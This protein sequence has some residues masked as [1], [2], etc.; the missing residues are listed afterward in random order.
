MPDKDFKTLF[1]ETLHNYGV[2][3][4][5]LA[6][7]SAIPERYLE[8]MRAGNTEVLPP[9]PYVRGYLVKI[10]TI[11]GGNLDELWSAYKH[12]SLEK[13]SG[14]TD[15]LP[16]NRFLLKRVS[17]GKISL[18]IVT[19]LLVLYGITR[20]NVILGNPKLIIR[21][22]EEASVISTLNTILIKGGVDPRDKLT[23]NGEGVIVESNG[24]FSTEWPLT[25]GENI[26]EIKAKRF[27]GKEEVITKK[28]IYNPQ[29]STNTAT[30]TTSE[31]L[32]WRSNEVL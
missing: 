16:T 5:K 7:I 30:S 25:L 12:K 20:Y 18:A 29:N 17:K 8:A 13:T 2:G 3:I 28:V 14:P 15:H 24:T 22:P 19:V 31:S 11:T 26:L 9:D 6:E 4:T 21:T 32:L 23:I 27:L 10:A 1:S